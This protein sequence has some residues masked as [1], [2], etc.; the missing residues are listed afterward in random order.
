MFT[1]FE[2]QLNPCPAGLRAA[3][4]AYSFA[5]LAT[6]LV[7]IGIM[8][9]ATGN[10]LVAAAEIHLRGDCRTDGVLVLLEDVAEIY[11]TNPDEVKAIGKIDLIPAPAEGQKRHLRLREIEDLLVLRGVNLREHRFSGAS[12]VTI[13]GVVDATSTRSDG[14]PQAPISIRQVTDTVHQAI[15]AYLTEQDSE[16]ATS[17]V[18]L[19]ITDEQALAIAH[20]KQSAVSG[21]E[22]PW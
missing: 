13:V 9:L 16:N 18:K 4:L 6:L 12:K 3:N 2:G 15:V 5:G 17:I 20:V 10:H 8:R 1:A 7:A 11:S 14:L 22:S 21:G 19:T